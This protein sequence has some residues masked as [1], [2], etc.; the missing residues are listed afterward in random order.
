MPAFLNISENPEQ[1]KYHLESINQWIFDG[2]IVAGARLAADY[3]SE[4]RAQPVTNGA[5]AFNGSARFSLYYPDYRTSTFHA[6]KYLLSLNHTRI[7][8]IS[9]HLNALSSKMRLEGVQQ[10][11]ADQQFDFGKA[12]TLSLELCAH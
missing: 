9:G 7:A 1:Q 5:L 12:E 3:L 4:F 2:L 6:V 11:L 8:Y 10:T